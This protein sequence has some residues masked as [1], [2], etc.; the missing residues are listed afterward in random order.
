MS[1][2]MMMAPGR[3]LRA[4]LASDLKLL[5]GNITINGRTFIGLQI[6]KLRERHSVASVFSEKYHKV[7]EST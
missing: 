7:T 3:I 6:E 1:G 2:Y 4:G 5:R